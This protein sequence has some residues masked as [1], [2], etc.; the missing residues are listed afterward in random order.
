V[1]VLIPVF[2]EP[3]DG[4]LQ[5]GDAVETTAADRLLADQTKPTLHQIEPGGTGRSEVE[6]E[7]R[8]RD[9]P[10]AH[11]RVTMSPIV[12]AGQMELAPAITARQRIEEFDEL[13]VAMAPI[14]TSMDLA[15]AT[16]SAANKLLVPWR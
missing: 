8:M 1:G 5:Y 7:A 12:V 4:L 9:Q 14:A 16:S 2:Y 15:L 6:M 3:S 13:L 11:G 10:L